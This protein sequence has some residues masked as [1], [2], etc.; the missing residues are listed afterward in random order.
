MKVFVVSIT[1][2]PP[3]PTTLR[4]ARI[5]LNTR[6]ARIVNREPFTIHLRFETADYT[7]PATVGVDTG[8]QIPRCTMGQ[9]LQAIWLAPSFAALAS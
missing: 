7:Q 9:S 4:M 8:S 3:M 6:R 1:G 2:K 5:W